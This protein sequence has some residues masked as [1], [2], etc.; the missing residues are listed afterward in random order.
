MYLQQVSRVFRHT[1]RW[2]D[3]LFDA[4]PL[5]GL[6]ARRA[7]LTRPDALGEM[8]LSTLRGE[9]G[10]QAKEVERLAEWLATLGSARRRV[11]VERAA[12]RPGSEDPGAP[13]PR[14]GGVSTLQGEDA[15]LDSLPEP[16]RSQAWDL[17]GERCRELDA[18][19]PVSRYY[20]DVMTE[21]LGLDARPRPPRAQRDPRR[22]VRAGRRRRRTRP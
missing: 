18:V 8:T 19:L 22:R 1:P 2:V 20:A 12:G 11:P 10:N 6:A 16:H 15:F 5:L 7:A 4:R 9:S 13:G 21:R 14:A 3:R 17:V